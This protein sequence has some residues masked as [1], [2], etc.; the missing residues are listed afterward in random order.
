MVRSATILSTLSVALLLVFVKVLV[1]SVVFSPRYPLFRKIPLHSAS[2]LPPPSSDLGAD[3]PTTKNLDDRIFSAADHDILRNVSFDLNGRPTIFMTVASHHDIPFLDNL[4]C[5]LKGA[6]AKDG[7]SLKYDVLLVAL[8]KKMLEHGEKVDV[9]TT[10]VDYL[11]TRAT[12]RITGGL[13]PFFSVEFAKV[14]LAKLLAVHEVLEAKIDVIFVDADVVVCSDVAMHLRDIFFLLGKPNADVF[15]Q[16]DGDGNQEG[17]GDLRTGI[18]H[19]RS[20]VGAQALFEG[21]AAVVHAH[22][23][24][25]NDD[26]SLWNLCWKTRMGGES[27][28]MQSAWGGN[29]KREF[30]WWMR[31]ALLEGLPQEKFPYIGTPGDGSGESNSWEILGLIES[32]CKNGEIALLH[33]S[34]VFSSEKK[35]FLQKIGLWF[36]DDD[37][38]CISM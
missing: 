4:R 12:A 18:F 15:L 30:C 13:F 1:W 9:A 2:E 20:G 6:L 3:L 32:Q 19:A 25:L 27:L 33:P 21:L 11:S 17:D 34:R 22:S 36:V 23:S 7:S 8:D 35:A 31:K 26:V 29:K 24:Y 38:R 10:F 5:S 16:K 28:E 37:G 14:S